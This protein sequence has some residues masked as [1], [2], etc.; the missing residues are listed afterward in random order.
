MIS[1]K[2]SRKQNL[3]RPNGSSS[4][5]EVFALLTE[6]IILFVGLT[7]IEFR[8]PGLKELISGYLFQCLSLEDRWNDLLQVLFGIAKNNSK[9][10]RGSSKRFILFV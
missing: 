3:I 2:K 7:T 8:K 4:G 1:K 6:V 5:K 9:S 10:L